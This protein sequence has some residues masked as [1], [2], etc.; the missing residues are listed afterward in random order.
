M[1]DSNKDTLTINFEEML[2]LQELLEIPFLTKR[3]LLSSVAKVFDPMGLISPSI[4]LMKILFQNLCKNGVDW[5]DPVDSGTQKAWDLW[6]KDLTEAKT[7]SVNRCIF[8]QCLSQAESI[9]LHGFGDASVPAYGSCI[10]IRVDYG[11]Q[12]NV[13]LLSSKTRVAPLKPLTIPRKELL[14]ALL[15]ARLI[16]SVKSAL[17]HFIHIK[18]VN[19]WQA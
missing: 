5:D 9:E 4:I 13:H 8:K 1:W 6:L 12:V 2:S 3:V 18:S 11:D 7:F 14:S 15:T 16:N 19:C 17:G 10:Y